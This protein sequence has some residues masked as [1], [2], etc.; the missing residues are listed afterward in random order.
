MN[1]IKLR[2][3]TVA[4]FLFIAPSLAYAQTAEQVM[5]NPA[6]LRELRARIMSS[7][8]TPEQVRARLRAEGYPENLLDAYLG[9]GDTGSE[10]TGTTGTGTQQDVLGAVSALGIVDTVDAL[11]LRCS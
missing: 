11:T 10:G 2:L 6:L 5:Q 3:L 4:A 8:L 1:S 7:G 9:G